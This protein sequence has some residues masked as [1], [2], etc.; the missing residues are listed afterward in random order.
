MDNTN[1]SAKYDKTD[2]LIPFKKGER[3]SEEQEKIAKMG[4][5]A[6]GIARKEKKL[7]KE[8]ILKRMKEDDWNKMI[9]NLIARSIDSSKDFEVLRDT[10][11]QKPQIEV[12]ATGT[13]DFGSAT[14]KNNADWFRF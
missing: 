11:G 2:N 1:H 5:I 6:S 8:E 7:F 10:V 12:N 3:T 4:G 9:D 13:F 14:L